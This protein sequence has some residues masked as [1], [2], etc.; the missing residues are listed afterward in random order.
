MD[1][2]RMRMRQPLAFESDVYLLLI[3]LHKIF[4]SPTDEF[5]THKSHTHDRQSSNVQFEFAK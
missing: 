4:K 5:L 1:I 3:L 2:A